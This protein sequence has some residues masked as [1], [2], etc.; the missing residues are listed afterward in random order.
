MDKDEKFALQLQEKKAPLC[1]HAI[2]RFSLDLVEAQDLVDHVI[3][4]AYINRDK[5]REGTKLFSWL[6]TILNNEQINILRKKNNH[7]KAVHSSSLKS[8]F[9]KTSEASATSALSLQELESLIDSLPKLYSKPFL[10][11]YQGYEYKEIASILGS[12]VGTIKSRIFKARKK[13]KVMIPN[14]HKVNHGRLDLSN[15]S[16]E[17]HPGLG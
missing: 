10:L 7:K 12:P 9:G 15:P 8:G 6:C 17:Q 13:L 3:T 5:Y 14:A 4:K 1:S 11:H 2:K 16:D